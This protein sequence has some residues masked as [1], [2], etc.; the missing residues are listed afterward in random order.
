MIPNTRV[1]WAT[2]SAGVRLDALSDPGSIQSDP[3]V[4][5]RQ[6]S[7]VVVVAQDLQGTAYQVTLPNVDYDRAALAGLTVED[8]WL[9]VAD[10]DAQFGFA[11]QGQLLALP[12]GDHNAPPG[13]VV[14]GPLTFQQIENVKAL[15]AAGGLRGTKS[16]RVTSGGIVLADV[17]EAATAV[18]VAADQT[19]TLTMREGL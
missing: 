16:V 6:L 10:P 4:D 18:A 5:T 17:A 19:V 8:A 2:A 3:T 7:G 15:H 11:V 12:A 13:S 9:V 1:W 14:R